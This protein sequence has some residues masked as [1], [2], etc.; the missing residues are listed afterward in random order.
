[1]EEQKIIQR[2]KEG[3]QHQRLASALVS[4]LRTT[5]QMNNRI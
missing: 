2:G 1:M 3:K 5:D 4:K